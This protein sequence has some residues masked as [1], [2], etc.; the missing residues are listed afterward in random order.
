[1]APKDVHSLFPRP[2]DFVG[3]RATA[4]DGI[5]VVCWVQDGEINLGE[6]NLDYLG[7]PKVIIKVVKYGKEKQMREP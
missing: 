1:M 7:K 6:I 5:K 2:C 4:A 3:Y